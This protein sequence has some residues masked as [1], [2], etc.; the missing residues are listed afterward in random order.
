MLSNVKY[1]KLY[2]LKVRATEELIVWLIYS[3]SKHKSNEGAHKKVTGTTEILH[4]CSQG[5]T[6]KSKQPVKSSATKGKA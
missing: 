6:F 2:N 5:I 1:G 3:S 4:H